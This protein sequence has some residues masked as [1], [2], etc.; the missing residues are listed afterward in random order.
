MSETKALTLR[1]VAETLL[2]PLYTRA[3]ESQRPM[4]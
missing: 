2:I 3:M 4:H 1:G